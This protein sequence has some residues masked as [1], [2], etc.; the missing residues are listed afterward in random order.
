M[1]VKFLTNVYHFEAGKE[2][3]VADADA[4][5]YAK[6]GVAKRLWKKKEDKED[7]ES[8]PDEQP[9][10]TRKSTKKTTKKD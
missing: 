10:A 2:Y 1:K 9:K 8:K 3:E 7:D 4:A 5:V 6:L